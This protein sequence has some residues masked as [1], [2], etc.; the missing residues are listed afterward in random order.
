LHGE[1]GEDGV[2]IATE[3][4]AA[5]CTP[6]VLAE[7]QAA[8]P[9]GMSEYASEKEAVAPCASVNKAGARLA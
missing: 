4:P 5:I 1:I 3:P 6:T 9:V 8:L 2:T 7:A